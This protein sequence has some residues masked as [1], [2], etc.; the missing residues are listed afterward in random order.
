MPTRLLLLLLALLLPGP[1]SFGSPSTVTLPET[2]LFVSTLD[3]SL[4][5]VSKRTGSIKWTLKE[6]PVLQVPTHVEEPA[7]LPDPNDGS[8]YTLGGKNNEGLTKL[9]F[10]IPELVQA[11]PCRSSDG[12]LYM[13]KS[14]CFLPCNWELFGNEPQSLGK[15]RL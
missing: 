9:P 6:D 4:H 2:L 10:T 12:I 15:W 1:R 8:L 13:G 14:S 5:A 11:S 7:F 3:G